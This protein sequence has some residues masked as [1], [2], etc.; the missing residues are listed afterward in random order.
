MPNP[1]ARAIGRA[2]GAIQNEQGWRLL[3]GDGQ[4][5]I[6]RGWYAADRPAFG[7]AMPSPRF[8]GRK[9]VAAARR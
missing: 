2:T 9:S 3:R 1:G 4:H 8:R 6:A 5:G 7:P